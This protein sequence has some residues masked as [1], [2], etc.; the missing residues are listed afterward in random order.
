M[1][2]CAVSMHCITAEYNIKALGTKVAYI[3]FTQS[4]SQ[5]HIKTN[6]L[7]SGAIFPT[8]DNEYKIDIDTMLRPV[9]YKRILKQK[10]LQDMVLATYDYS[11]LKATMF[12]QS[13]KSTNT[14]SVQDDSRDVFSFIALLSSGDLV[15][16]QYLI[17]ANGCPWQAN[18]SLPVIEV[19]STKLG[20]LK[21]TK[22]E[23]SFKPLSR[24][25]TPYVDMITF[26]FVNEKTKLNVWVS[27]S[28]IPVKAV[29]KK[30]AV[31]MSWELIGI[32]P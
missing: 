30:K 22:Y 14:Y 6:S 2:L 32:K 26:N 3:S 9:K 21:T 5:L 29:V 27:D 7:K 19:I 23:V 24:K 12:R 25:E 13:D 15:K 17:D 4:S 1:M 8:F 18:V 20:K 11:K 16:R 31:F 28:K 10:N